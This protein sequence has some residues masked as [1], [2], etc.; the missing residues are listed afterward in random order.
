MDP[1]LFIPFIRTAKRSLHRLSNEARKTFEIALIAALRDPCLN[2][3][4]LLIVPVK[5]YYR[6][7][8]MMW[9]D[10]QSAVVELIFF[11]AGVAPNAFRMREPPC[12]HSS[13]NRQSASP[14]ATSAEYMQ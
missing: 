3:C 11:K 2:A 5:G 13:D 10:V 14:P 7:R 4:N 9:L 1:Q 6:T 12:G 8:D